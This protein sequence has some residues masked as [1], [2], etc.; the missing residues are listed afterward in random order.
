[1]HSDTEAYVNDQGTFTTPTTSSPLS[2]DPTAQPTTVIHFFQPDGLATGTP[3]VYS[4]LLSPIGEL[5]KG[6][7]YYVI[8]TDPYDLELADSPEGAQNGVAITL[9]A[10]NA[11]G[12]QT[13]TPTAPSTALPL[14]FT[15]SSVESTVL[16]FAAPH[17]L[18]TGQPV[19][20]RAG[21]AAIG[22]LSSG[23][24]YYVINVGSNQIEL[25]SS[26]AQAGAGQAI[27][28]DFSQAAGTQTF[29]PISFSVS[30]ATR[31]IVVSV[32][33]GFSLS[34]QQTN[35]S[36]GNLAIA[37]A[38]GFNEIADTT[39]AYL[40]N[41][42]VTT[43]QLAV[44]ADHGGY[45]GSLTLGA[46]GTSAPAAS[47]GNGSNTAVAGS[48][49]I[50]VELPDTEAFVR[51]AKLTLDGDS[52]V[53]AKEEAEIVAIAGA[54]EFGGNNGFGVAV[55]VNLIGFEL[56]QTSEPAQTEA[57][58][59]D[60]PV[61]L[62]AGNLSVTA[63][64][65]APTGQPR[66]LA[67]AV[68]VG[69]LKGENTHAVDGMVSVNTI[70]GKTDASVEYLVITG[71]TGMPA[72]GGLDVEASDSSGITADGGGVSLALAQGG[73]Q[74]VTIGASVGINAINGSV[75]AHID[76]SQV[77]T[78]GDVKVNATSN[79]T[80][81][82]H[83]IGG[84]AGVSTSGS[85][86]S[87]GG[88]TL[89]LAGAGSGNVVSIDTRAY[90]TGD[91]DATGWDVQSTG[92]SVKLTATDGASITANAGGFSLA[93]LIGN[94]KSFVNLAVGISAAVNQISD[95]AIA[96]IDHSRVSANQ[97]LDLTS[98]LTATIQA[99]TLGGAASSGAAGGA[100]GRATRS[101]TRSKV[102]SPAV[103]EGRPARPSM[104]AAP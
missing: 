71:P 72:P 64:A 36:S 66:I 53:A 103:K 98:T 20:Y 69:L 61:A 21:S 58:I 80:I 2:L 46:D 93:L 74:N 95:N 37:G 78:V 87:G 100:R 67:I 27:A 30:A 12:M 7:T 79:P 17:G 26:L 42:T 40:Q 3:V 55:A 77:A 88:L 68:S 39:K 102:I 50:N 86:D 85:D 13:L 14:T 24:R 90:I 89:A 41:A 82:S 28:L 38:V 73:D 99:L 25:A 23:Q 91:P 32:D 51:D 49:S 52:Q 33:G 81:Q 34:Q 10:S 15:P 76:D 96:E 44:T 9:D 92:G 5:K 43:A 65:A 6:T 48:V 63:G 19:E 62:D 101:T 104:P 97:D 70:Q 57:Y 84:S 60:S 18:Q 75:H 54:G 16:T 56:G 8:A 4:T 59:L 83:T 29:I 22:G 35:S 45:I 11:S 31:T 1:M 47:G 94:P